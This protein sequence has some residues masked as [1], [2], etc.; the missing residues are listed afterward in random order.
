MFGPCFVI[1]YFVSVLFCNH[2]NGEKRAGCFAL[3]IFLMSY[4]SQC[5]VALT[6][7]AVGWS[8]MCDCGISRSNSF[9]F[10]SKWHSDRYCNL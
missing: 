2:L 8:A 3:T 4:D 10:F 5:S 6:R 9:A 1:H 7:G